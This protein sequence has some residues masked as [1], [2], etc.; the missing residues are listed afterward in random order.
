M[1]E[2]PDRNDRSYRRWQ[3]LARS[4]ITEKMR[5]QR[6]G[7]KELALFLEKLGIEETAEQI[8]R[9][10]NRNRFSAAFLLA[11]LDALEVEPTSRKSK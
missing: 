1:E 11:C 5:K 4:L 3:A 7:Y 8:N 6:I 10:V 9:K 2:F